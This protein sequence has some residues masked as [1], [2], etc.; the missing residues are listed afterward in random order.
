MRLITEIIENLEYLHEEKDGKKYL[1][2][3]GPYI[4]VDTPN[5]NNRIYTRAIME[6]VIE[7]Y[8]RDKVNNGT[9]FG[10]FG[11]PANGPNINEEKI[12]HRITSLSWDKNHVIGK[13]LI[14]DEGPSGKLMRK[15]IPDYQP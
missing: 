13:A 11:H 15:S 3:S 10:E 9:A 6:P 4:S 2:V 1:Y 7:S 8:L 12:S 14:L 5:R